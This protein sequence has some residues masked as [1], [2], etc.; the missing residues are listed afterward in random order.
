MGPPIIPENKPL[1]FLN[2]CILGIETDRFPKQA[3]FQ[4]T[5]CGSQMQN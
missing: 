2:S 1:V 4:T 3:R 5:G